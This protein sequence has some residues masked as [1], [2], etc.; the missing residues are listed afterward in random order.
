MIT[1][2]KLI[3]FLVAQD[4][5]KDHPLALVPLDGS[6][7]EFVQLANLPDEIQ[8]DC[9]EQADKLN[10]TPLGAIIDFNGAL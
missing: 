3:G 2:I 1:R 10:V 9:T 4:G 5:D 8:N 7:T 6:T